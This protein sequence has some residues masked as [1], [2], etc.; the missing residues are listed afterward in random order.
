[1]L[2]FKPTKYQDMDVCPELGDL[3]QAVF[4]SIPSLEFHACHSRPWGIDAKSFID[5]VEVFDGEQKVGK[6]EWT[7]KYTCNG[8]IKVYRISSKRIIKERGDKNAKTTE[9][10]KSAIKIAKQAFVKDT[11]GA[12][13]YTIHEEFHRK[14]NDVLWHYNHNLE[15]KTRKLTEPAIEYLIGKVEGTIPTIDPVIVQY[16][17]GEDFITTRDNCR[18]A[19]KVHQSLSNGDGLILYV[20]RN[21]KL[22][23]VYPKER[24][25]KKL[26]STYDLPNN[27]Q[28]KYAILK[29]M[30]YRQP[31]D[32]IGIKLELKVDDKEGDY[33][34][35]MPGE[36][37]VTH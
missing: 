6:L 35:L 27:Y 15:T 10:A 1:M 28:E 21:E 17:K 14:Y 20:D 31:I 24:T 23:A 29:I 33:Y 25:L 7:N 2:I 19:Q 34:Y 8:Y 36:V 12:R 22:T 30:E 37:I 4:A 32:G 11:D 5:A 16:I 26:D 18:I 13:A 3:I 9:S